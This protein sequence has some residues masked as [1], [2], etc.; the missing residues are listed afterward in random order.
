MAGNARRLFLP[1]DA[2]FFDDERVI[3]A[4]EKAGWLLL[5]MFCR[6]KQLGKDGTIT[7]AQIGRLGVP[8]TRQRLAAL[9]DVGLICRIDGGYEIPA[10]LKWN[11]RQS[12]R[13]KRSQD[14]RDRANRRWDSN[15]E[16]GT[17]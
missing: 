10:W 6:I 17:A 7:D 1:L 2:A 16:E 14:A 3:E 12:V 15:S 9:V 4:G 8:G 13:E 5:A 11:E